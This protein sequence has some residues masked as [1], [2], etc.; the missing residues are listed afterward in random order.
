MKCLNYWAGPEG[1]ESPHSAARRRA[2]GQLG[3]GSDPPPKQG[4]CLPRPS[5]FPPPWRS[6]VRAVMVL[7]EDEVG[8]AV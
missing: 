3:Q 8:I 4:N 6:W 7:W 5:C 1:S 2:K